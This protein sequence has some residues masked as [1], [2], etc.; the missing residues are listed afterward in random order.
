MQRPQK[1][2]FGE[3]RDSGVCGVLGLLHRLQVRHHITTGK[4]ALAAACLD[5]S[6][7]IEGRWS[8]DDCRTPQLDD[9]IKNIVICREPKSL[10]WRGIPRP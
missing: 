9:G 3:I 6:P 7:E 5:S 1:I 8:W 4:N 2:T 10:H